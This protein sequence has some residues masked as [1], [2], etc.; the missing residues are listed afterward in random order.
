MRLSSS[1]R[2]AVVDVVVEL[3]NF[4]GSAKVMRLMGEAAMEINQLRDEVERLYAS[5][6]DRDE[7]IRDLERRVSNV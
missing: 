3:E 5:L 7:T 2:L 1:T 4:S 6:R